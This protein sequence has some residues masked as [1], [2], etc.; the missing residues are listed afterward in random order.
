MT[1]CN[2]AK[3]MG[4]KKVHVDSQMSEFLEERMFEENPIPLLELS[5]CKSKEDIVRMQEKYKMPEEVEIDAAGDNY[6][7]ES[8][9]IYP[10]SKERGMLRAFQITDK[11]ISGILE[12]S[13]NT[14][15]KG[16][17]VINVTHCL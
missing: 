5:C 8:A 2:I 12:H 17:C 9:K 13:Y 14:D 15:G 4:V 6:K 10:E 11:L 1:A 7:A 3:A 16:I